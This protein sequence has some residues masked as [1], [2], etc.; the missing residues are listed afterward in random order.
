MAVIPTLKQLSED[1]VAGIEAQLQITLP[2]NGPVFLRAWSATYAA[3][4]KLLYLYIGKVQKNVFPDTAE[5]EYQG[6]TLERFGRGYLNRNPFE[7]VAGTYT[8]GITGTI[9]ATINAGVIFKADDS[10][11]AAGKLYEL[12]SSKT[13]TSE[14][15]TIT[16]KALEAGVDSKLTVGDT[17]TA[18]QPLTNVDDVATMQTEVTEPKA[19]EDIEDYR[20]KILQAIRL[21]TQ[22]GAAGD[23]RLWAADAQGVK[24]IY[25]YTKSGAP[26]E[27]NIYVEAATADSTDGKGTPSSTLLTEVE[28]V[29]ELDPDTTL[30]LNERG[31]LP[32]TVLNTNV[33]AINP[34][35]IDIVI[36][37]YEDITDDKKD[38]ILAGVTAAINKVRPFIAAADAVSD[39]NDKVSVN[40]ITYMILQAVPG[41]VFTDVTLKVDNVSM[42]SKTFDNGNIPYLNS[43]T[44][45]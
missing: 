13:L 34:L 27:T 15:D 45:D 23:Y 31:R 17:V 10:T 30:S 26:G 36:S 41:S 25:P 33:Q 6:G 21:E 40:T 3:K 29:I 38:L 20:A 24:A 4:L 39:R 19:A 42:S 1:L 7:P 35:D 32:L 37:G 11:K 8:F 9:G 44:Y 16:L 43:I 5:T 28:E 14:N 12:E 18:T 2:T 22:G